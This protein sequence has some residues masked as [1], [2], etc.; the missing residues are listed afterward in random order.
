VATALRQQDNIQ[1]LRWGIEA[2][3]LLNKCDSASCSELAT[4]I[5]I[6]RAAVYRVVGTLE[7]R[8]HVS[9]IGVPR[10]GRYRLALGVRT[11]SGGFHGERVLLQVAHPRL[12]QCT[13]A[14]GWPLALGAP[15]GDC[16]LVI[17]STDQATSRLLTRTRAGRFEPYLDSAIGQ[18]CLANLAE[19]VRH[20]SI[21]RLVADAVPDERLRTIAVSSVSLAAQRVRQQGFSLHEPSCARE[22]NLAIPFHEEGIFVGALDMRYMRVASNGRIGH[23]ERLRVLM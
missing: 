16:A 9:R 18:V 19:S 10:R 22:F 11:L 21:T 5:G 4:A 7:A 12:S 15:A 1:T 6:S 3:R 20:A 17:F 23:E 2:L 14:I 13:A 8:G